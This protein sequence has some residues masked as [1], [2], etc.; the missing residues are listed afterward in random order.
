MNWIKKLNHFY[1]LTP[2]LYE[3]QFDEAGFTWVNHGDRQNSVLSYVRHGKAKY[4]QLLVVCNFTP[5]VREQYQLVMPIEAS[6]REVL[7]SD[8]EEFGGTNQHFNKNVDTEVVDGENIIT[9]KL[10]PLSVLVFEPEFIIEHKQDEE[11]ASLVDNLNS[12]EE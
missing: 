6:W 5:V 12:S 3:K 10:P 2:A 8:Q 11:L 1:L 7:N 4:D 9:L